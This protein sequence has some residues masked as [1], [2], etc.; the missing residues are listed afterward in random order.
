LTENKRL[1]SFLLWPLAVAVLGVLVAV[2]IILNRPASGVRAAESAAAFLITQQEVLTCADNAIVATIFEAKRDD[3][4]RTTVRQG[5]D[6]RTE[7]YVRKADGIMIRAFEHVGVKSTIQFPDALG[8]E[9]KPESAC[10][11]TQSGG[12]IVDA[13]AAGSE[14]LHGFDTV[15]IVTSGP[16]VR[17][18]AWHAPG[19]GCISLRRVYEERN[20]GGEWQP[21]NVLETL[22]IKLGN[23]P[24]SLFESNG[25]EMTPSSAVEIVERHTLSRSGLSSDRA[26][27]LVQRLKSKLANKDKNY[28]AYR[29]K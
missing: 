4:S 8:G 21:I 6:G 1:R 18:T 7:K 20:K 24:A 2:M 14:Q 17:I 22:A 28:A 27:L 10:L 15:K 16:G 29:P 23:P 3:G 13:L 11:K 25:A 19:L 5:P 26:E 9:L 12:G